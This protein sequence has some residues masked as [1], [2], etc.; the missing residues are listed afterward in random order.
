MMNEKM[1]ISECERQ[2]SI[3]S[4]K[5]KALQI[6]EQ[7]KENEYYLSNAGFDTFDLVSYITTLEM[8]IDEIVN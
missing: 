4:A 6:V 5:K 1:T 2:I 3:F 7:F 8:E